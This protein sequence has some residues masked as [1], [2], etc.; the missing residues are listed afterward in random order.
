M[1]AFIVPPSI[2]YWGKPFLYIKFFGSRKFSEAQ[3]CCL[4]LI[5]LRNIVP[6]FVFN[7]C[8]GMHSP[9]GSRAGECMNVLSCYLFLGMV[10]GA[11][12]RVCACAHVVLFILHATLMSHVVCGLC[13]H[14]TLWHYQ[15]HDTI[16]GKR[17]LNINMYFDFLYNVYFKYFLF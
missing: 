6:D 2:I 1:K 3:T 8:K 14:H 15:I 4:L 13:L 16:F 7:F 5:Y 17:L 12:A 11:G 9:A 10:G